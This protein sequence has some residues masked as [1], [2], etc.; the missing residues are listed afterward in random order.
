M[1]HKKELKKK[2]IIKSIIFGVILYFEI[3]RNKKKFV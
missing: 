2:K 1:L 3:F